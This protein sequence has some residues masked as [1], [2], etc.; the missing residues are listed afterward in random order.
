MRNALVIIFCFISICLPAFGQLPASGDLSGNFPNPT[1]A[2]IQG[3]AVDTSAPSNR[4]SLIWDSPTSKWTPGFTGWAD[5]TGKPTTFAPSAH[6]HPI[7]DITA[8]P[9]GN[10]VKVVGG[11]VTWASCGGTGTSQWT[12][13]GSNISFASGNVLIGTTSDTGAKLTVAGLSRT[14]GAISSDIIGVDMAATSGGTAMIS[15]RNAS[16]S[17]RWN[18]GTGVAET[19]SGNTGA[20][21][22]VWRYGDAGDYLGAPVRISRAT[23]AVSVG[24]LAVGGLFSATSVATSTAQLVSVGTPHQLNF[25][26]GGSA[27]TAIDA[28]TVNNVWRAHGYQATITEI[29]CWTDAGT[30][31]LTLKDSAG[32]AIAS[33]LSCST[34]GASTAVINA[35]GVIAYGEGLGFTTASVSGVKNLSIS[36]KYTRSY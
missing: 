36:I 27:T 26:Y 31:S 4:N 32:N 5:V 18:I 11:L 13:S 15:L 2:K 16:S 20:D 33:A 6:G 23:G 8:G 35:Y 28:T 29:A 9:E 7:T 12:T 14:V 25:V 24:D 21:F 10:C 19:G 30:V 3:R 22:F 17:T 1:V 34:T